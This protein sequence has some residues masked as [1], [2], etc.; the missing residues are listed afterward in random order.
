MLLNNYGWQEV[1]KLYQY[2]VGNF[3]IVVVVVKKQNT[4]S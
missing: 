4:C 1:T 2:R 3:I